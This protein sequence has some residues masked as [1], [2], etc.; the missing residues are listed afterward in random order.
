VIEHLAAHRYERDY[1]YRVRAQQPEALSLVERAARMIYLNR[2]G[3]NGL[4]RVNAAGRFNVPFGRY[5]NPRICDADNLQ[6]VARA[7][8]GVELERAPFER[9]LERAAPGDVV[10]FDPPYVPLSTTARF[11]S[12]ARDGFGPDAQQRLAEVFSALAGRGVRVMLSN[13]DTPLVHELYAGFRRDAVQA[14]RAVNSRKDRRGP[15]GELLVLG[16]GLER[17]G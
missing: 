12:Y 10:Y 13:S 11:T 4:Y 2:C 5:R 8:R 17:G 9:V 7:L 14:R 6:A 1:F 15:V 16:G 3:F